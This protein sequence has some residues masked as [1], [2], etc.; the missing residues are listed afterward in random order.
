MEPF[1]LLAAPT[2]QALEG[3]V[4]VGVLHWRSASGGLG[5]EEIVNRVRLVILPFEFSMRRQIQ[6]ADRGT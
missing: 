3:Q 5:D 1:D 2:G 4:M 6:R